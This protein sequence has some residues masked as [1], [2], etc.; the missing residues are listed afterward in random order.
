MKR[1]SQITATQA[2]KRQKTANENS[3]SSDPTFIKY[4]QNIDIE[5]T[6]GLHKDTDGK[7]IYNSDNKQVLVILFGKN[8]K[9]SKKLDIILKYLK[10]GGDNDDKEIVMIGIDKSIQKMITVIEILKQ[11]IQQIGEEE[12]DG[13]NDMV[14]KIKDSKKV[15][16]KG[17]EESE[18]GLEFNYHQFNY[19]DFTIIE[20]K[21]MKTVSGDRESATIG[22]VYDKALINDVLKNKVVNVPVL[23]SYIKF[24]KSKTSLVSNI[25]QFKGLMNNGWSGQNS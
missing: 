13:K 6:F 3:G 4:S 20:R 25:N 17:V 22:E 2:D 15:L 9:I 23:Y 19:I 21:E 7:K 11:K 5:K 8:F 24:E 10:E 16:I 12:E 14:A 18:V 1:A